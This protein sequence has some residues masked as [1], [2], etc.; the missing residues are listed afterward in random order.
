MNYS[1]HSCRRLMTSQ[2]DNLTHYLLCLM[3][4]IG[5]RTML[6]T[7]PLF[8]LCCC[9]DVYVIHPTMQR[10]W[11]LI[12]L[13]LM[14]DQFCHEWWNWGRGCHQE[15]TKCIRQHFGGEK[16]SS[17]DQDLEAYGSWQCKMVQ[18]FMFFGICFSHWILS[19]LLLALV[20]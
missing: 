7:Q 20:A 9:D 10:N 8:L 12:W 16:N 17:R 18:S 4:R 11:G 15:D 14:N 1:H 3:V 19:Y 2:Y 6:D 13:N 5:D